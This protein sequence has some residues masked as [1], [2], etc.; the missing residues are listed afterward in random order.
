MAVWLYG[1]EGNAFYLFLARPLW[2][3]R[4]RLS[5][6]GLERFVRLLY[7]F[8]W[9]YMT[10]C[11]VL[12][13]P[14]ADYMRR[15]MLPLTPDKRRVVIYD[16]LNPAYAKYYT[17]DEA[18]DAARAARIHDIQLH[19]RHGISWTVVGN[20]SMTAPLVSIVA[21]V[22]NE[23]AT[24]REFMATLGATAAR[25]LEPRYQF[26]FVL[27][28][29]GS[30]DGTLTLAKSLIA[31]EPRLRVVEL[32]RNFGQ[33]AALQ[34]GLGARAATSWSRWTPICSTFRRIS[35][36]SWIRIEEGLRPGLRMAARSPGRRAAPLAVARGELLIRAMSGLAIHDVGTTYRAYRADLVQRAAAARRAA[37]V[38]AGSRRAWSAR[39]SPR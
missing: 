38:R 6:Q 20:A 4:R 18:R 36:C 32:R 24:L 29:D 1:R 31:G 2:W 7:P 33:T 9:C 39:A 3:L 17:R 35:R 12:P 37:P 28:D 14:L 26:E 10:A 19:H 27:V 34:A 23:A 30:T 5:H 11:R 13:L 22:Y 15:V 21:P 8:F 16:Q 25:A